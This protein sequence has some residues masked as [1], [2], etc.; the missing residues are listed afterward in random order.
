MIKI[1]ITGSLASGKSTASRFLSAKHGPLFSA[2]SAVKEIYKSSSFNSLISKKFKLKNNKHI[3][4]I[5]NSF[6][7]SAHPWNTRKYAK[8]SKI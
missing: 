1:G 6:C 2:D 7:Y 3:K 8:K 4:K 5:Q